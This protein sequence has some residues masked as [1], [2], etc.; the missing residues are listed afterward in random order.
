MTDADRFQRNRELIGQCYPPF[1]RCVSRIIAQMQ[2]W[3]WRPRIQCAWR[4]PK[5]QQ[6]AFLTHHS[7]VA[8][9]Y[10][11]ATANGK[12]D[13]LAVDLLDDDHPLNSNLQYSV[14]LARAARA[15][16]C[17]TG[18]LWDLD[19]A[20]EMR[21]NL[22]IEGRPDFTTIGPDVKLGFDPTHIQP[23]K[24]SLDQARAGERPTWLMA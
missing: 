24:F 15:Q 19:T 12:P 22:I 9:S 10:H 8:W 21:L 2:A 1:G 6:T 5:D 20:D 23:A 7:E 13:A 17:E 18:I 16:G 3:G 14:E 11:N 4:D